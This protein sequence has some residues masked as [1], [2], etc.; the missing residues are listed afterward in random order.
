MNPATGELL[1]TVR[2]AGAAA[3]D[4]AVRAARAAQPAWAALSGTERGRILRRADAREWI[5]SS[6]P[7]FPAP[8]CWRGAPF[9]AVKL[10]QNPIMPT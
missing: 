5:S 1:A 10:C 3:V 7:C 6:V 9:L 4:A 2:V 8:E